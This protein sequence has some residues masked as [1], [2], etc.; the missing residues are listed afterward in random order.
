MQQTDNHSPAYAR[1]NTVFSNYEEFAK[2]FKCKKGTKM[3][4]PA[5]RCEVW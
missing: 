2:A 3:N 1:I 5:K 4:N